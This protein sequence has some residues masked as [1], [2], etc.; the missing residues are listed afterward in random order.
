MGAM[1]HVHCYPAPSNP[2]GVYP[3]SN[4]TEPELIS[5]A[6]PEP[7]LWG[8]DLDTAALLRNQ[9]HQGSRSTRGAQHTGT[10]HH[11]RLPNAV[12]RSGDR[13]SDFPRAVCPRRAH[14]SGTGMEERNSPSAGSLALPRA[15]CPPA[16]CK[17]PSNFTT[18]QGVWNSN[19]TAT[20][21][22]LAITCALSGLCC[23]LYYNELSVG[24]KICADGESELN[25]QIRPETE[26]RLLCLENLA[27]SALQR[28]S[29]TPVY[30]TANFEI[31]LP[32]VLNRQM[33]GVNR[34]PVTAHLGFR[35]IV[36]RVT[37]A[38][39]FFFFCKKP[40][41]FPRTFFQAVP[42]WASA[43]TWMWGNDSFRNKLNQKKKRNSV[44]LICFLKLQTFIHAWSKWGIKPEKMH[45]GP[46]TALPSEEWE[47]ERPFSYCPIVPASR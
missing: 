4:S 35:D 31:F 20:A 46:S 17:E 23:S 28:G 21:A 7:A 3:V 22:E 18:T 33:Q 29:E 9:E 8:A 13:S 44:N 19:E 47:W 39:T 42:I 27:G 37:L 36:L 26:L 32:E 30:F 24:S 2:G 25:A 6:G 41:P 16:C 5:F 10:H 11:L 45:W 14:Y 34:S 43:V 38:P 12:S 1:L 40:Y 15:L